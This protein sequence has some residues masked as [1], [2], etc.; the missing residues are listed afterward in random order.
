M[1]EMSAEA[2]ITKENLDTYLKEL[3]KQFRKLNGK[4]VPAEITLFNLQ[5]LHSNIPPQYQ[6]Y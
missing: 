5:I 3:A 2:P 4:S 1:C 6:I